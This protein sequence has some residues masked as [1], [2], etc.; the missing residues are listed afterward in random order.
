MLITQFLLYFSIYSALC[1][2]PS[3]FQSIIESFAFKLINYLV[4]PPCVQRFGLILVILS[5]IIN[6]IILLLIFQEYSLLETNIQIFSS[7]ETGFNVFDMDLSI[8]FKIFDIDTIIS[9]ILCIIS[10]QKIVFV[11]KSYNRLTPI[12]EVILYIEFLLH[13]FQSF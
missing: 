6:L 4:P 7:D 10:E 8:I 1:E 13:Y 5:T 2:N 12:I 3:D 9:I 11:C